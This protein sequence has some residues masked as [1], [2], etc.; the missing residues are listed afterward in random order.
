M[1][2]KIGP[3]VN[4]IRNTWNDLKCG[5][6]EGWRRSVGPIVSKMKKHYVEQGGNKCP[7]YNKK[8]EGLRI[9]HMACCFW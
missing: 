5:A 1:V 9:D 8:K 4:Q 3:F 7:M 6:G 2:L